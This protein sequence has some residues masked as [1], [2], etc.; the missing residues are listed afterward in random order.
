MVWGA[1]VQVFS[2]VRFFSVAVKWLLVA[3]MTVGQGLIIRH[4][5]SGLRCRSH[6]RRHSGSAQTSD[7]CQWLGNAV[8]SL[9][10][11]LAMLWPP[12]W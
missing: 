12:R 11:A 6:Y 4:T 7:I 9:V 5:I 10:W 1:S 2:V 8:W 3:M